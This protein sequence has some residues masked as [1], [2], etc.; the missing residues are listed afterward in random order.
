MNKYLSSCYYA[1]Q[2]AFV[3]DVGSSYRALCNIIKE[4][5]G[6]A[7]GAYYTFE[8]GKPISFNPFRNYQRFKESDSEA[9]NFIFTLMCTLWKNGSE[10]ISSSG[11]EV[12]K[13]QHWGVSLRLE[14]V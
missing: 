10:T 11:T 1:G 12:R 6:G 14:R 7:D 4:E 13:G 2:H 8:K 9:M 3:I 5:S